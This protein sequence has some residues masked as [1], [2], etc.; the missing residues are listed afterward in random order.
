MDKKI[1]LE[2]SQTGVF[3]IEDLGLDLG[4]QVVLLENRVTL[5][6]NAEL[7]VI[8]GE[9]P[10]KYRATVKGFKPTDKHRQP[11]GWYVQAEGKHLLVLDDAEVIECMQDAA[12]NLKA[13]RGG[14]VTQIIEIDPETLEIV[15]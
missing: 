7:P 12:D 13:F 10:T 14:A 3:C 6:T 1:N 15:D 9:K 8:S 2:G 11:T 5:V 4:G